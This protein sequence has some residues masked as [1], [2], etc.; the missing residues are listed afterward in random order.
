MLHQ[1]SPPRPPR[2]HPRTHQSTRSCNIRPGHPHRRHQK[3]RQAFRVNRVSRRNLTSLRLP[4]TR[5]LHFQTNHHLHL[6][7]S[8]PISED[9]RLRQ[10][11]V[12]RN[13]VRCQTRSRRQMNPA[14]LHVNRALRQEEVRARSRLSPFHRRPSKPFS[15][16]HHRRLRAHHPKKGN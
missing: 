7:T 12:P 3:Q 9:H 8:T 16:T 4:R 5:H 14:R 2:L 13:R 6:R 11:L 15:Q 10:T 1:L